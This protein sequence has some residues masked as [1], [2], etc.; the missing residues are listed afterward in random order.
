ME[1][2]YRSSSFG[3]KV[4]HKKKELFHKESKYFLVFQQQVLIGFVHF[5][6]DLDDGRDVLYLYEIQISSDCR[7]FG[8]GRL[9]IDL[10]GSIALSTGK[11][12]IM[13]TVFKMNHQ[14][15]RFFESM[16]YVYRKRSVIH[17]IL[18]SEK[19]EH[20]PTTVTT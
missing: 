11:E 18:D 9:L 13:L 16:G 17:P 4:D 8:L 2:M 14:A 3:W 1:A 5:R 10:I 6:L 19:I 15:R 20:V 12:L 7:R